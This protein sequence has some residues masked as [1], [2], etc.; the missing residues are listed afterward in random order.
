MS[1]MELDDELLQYIDSAPEVQQ[2]DEKHMKMLSL[3]LERAINKNQEH[4]IKFAGQ[5]EKYVHA[6]WNMLLDYQEIWCKVASCMELKSVEGRARTRWG[7]YC[8]VPASV[9]RSKRAQSKG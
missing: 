1:D 9:L 8:K 6:A 5:P 4:R 3:T 2:L 7:E